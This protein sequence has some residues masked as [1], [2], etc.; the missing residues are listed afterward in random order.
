MS[1]VMSPDLV[2]DTDFRENVRL[3]DGG[4][5]LLRPLGADDEQLFQTAFDK[6]SARSRYRRFIHSKRELSAD[7]LRFFTDVNGWDHFAIAAFAV[8]GKYGEGDLLGGARFYRLANEE[9]SA[10]MAFAVVD[11]A[12][13]RGIGRTLVTRLV[14]PASERGIDKLY[15]Y[16]LAENMPARKLLSQ[17]E[18]STENFD[19]VIAGAAG[20]PA[21]LRGCGG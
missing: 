13:H 9:S 11:H 18:P 6:L 7:E 19:D 21:R 15:F 12:Q 3:T 5:I 14:A 16:V 1:V 20:K 4:E 10:E 17:W 8:S 2:L